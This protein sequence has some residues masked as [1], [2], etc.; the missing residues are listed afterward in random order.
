MNWK[1]IIGAGSVVVAAVAVVFF[2]KTCSDQRVSDA[3]QES[4]K[5]IADTKQELVDMRRQ[6]DS[7]RKIVEYR[8]SVAAP[9][10]SV[11]VKKTAARDSGVIVVRHTTTPTVTRRAVASTKPVSGKTTVRMQENAKNNKNIIVPADAARGDAHSD[12]VRLYCVVCR[13]GRTRRTQRPQDRQSLCANSPLSDRL[14]GAR[15]TQ[16]CRSH[17]D[18]CKRHACSGLAASHSRSN[19]RARHQDEPRQAQGRRLGADHSDDCKHRLSL[20]L[21]SRRH[22]A[23]GLTILKA[24][25]EAPFCC[26]HELMSLNN[27]PLKREGFF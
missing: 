11:P 3:I 21:G 8:D 24:P 5:T 16:C 22:P 13:Q 14:R 2:A 4:Y 17:P 10:D 12:D 15:R 19:G 7:L 1:R 9:R 26:F 18:V 27:S 20:R 23:F 6:N 25:I